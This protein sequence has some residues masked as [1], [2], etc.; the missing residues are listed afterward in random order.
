MPKYFRAYINI[1]SCASDDGSVWYNH[2]DGH[3][4]WLYQQEMSRTPYISTDI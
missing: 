3:I 1:Y 2:G 4:L